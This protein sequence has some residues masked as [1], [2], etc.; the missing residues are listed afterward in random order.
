MRPD[1]LLAT[2]ERALAAV[3]AVLRIGRARVHQLVAPNGGID[4]ALL[5]REQI[6][7]HGLAWMA[8]YAEALRQIRQW[9]VRLDEAGQLGDAEALIVRV[10]F[11]EYLAQLAGGIAMSQ[12]EIVRPHDLGLSE[13]EIAPLRGGDAVRLVNGLGEARAALASLLGDGSPAVFGRIALGDPTLE[14]IRDQISRFADSAA[15]LIGSKLNERL[16]QQRKDLH[17]S[18]RIAIH[19]DRALVTDNSSQGEMLSA[20]RSKSSISSPIRHLR[21]TFRDGRLW[22]SLFKSSKK[23]RLKFRSSRPSCFNCSNSRWSA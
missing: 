10:A 2:T 4:A 7:V 1:E 16:G 13:D 19:S 5:D 20:T 12:G 3:E 14:M 21:V 22:A 23:A 6:A 15:R 8:T 18:A 17:L 11:G 9:A